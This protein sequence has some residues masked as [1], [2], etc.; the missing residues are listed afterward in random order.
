MKTLPRAV[1]G[2]WL[3]AAVA[4]PAVLAAGEPSFRF[5]AAAKTL[6]VNTGRLELTILGGAVVALKDTRTGE[7]FSAGATSSDLEAAKAGALC[8]QEPAVAKRLGI[9]AATVARRPRPSSPVAFR[10]TDARFGVL[11]YAGLDRGEAEDEW[12][13]HVRIEEQG[14][15][16][17][18]LELRLR[19]PEW[20]ASEVYL[21]FTKLTAPAVILGSGERFA[22]DEPAA[23]SRCMRI[24]N[25][26][27]APPLAVIEGA[28]GVVG[29]WP[30]GSVSA[31]DD[32]TLFHRPEHDEVVPQV[33]LAFHAKD[34]DTADEP[35]VTRSSWWRIAALPSWLD[36][37]KRYRAHLERTAGAR[38]LWEQT[39]AWVRGIHAVCTERPN[40]KDPALADA[41]YARLAERFD[42]QKLLLF[43][44]NG[45]C[46]LLFGDHRYMTELYYPKPQE[47]AA[48]RRHGFR[49]LG[50]HPYV[51]V[52]SP[53]GRQKHLEETRQRGFGVPADF[54][55]RPDY[56]GPPDAAAFDDYFRPVAAGYYAPLET[57]PSLWT[58]HPGAKIVRE[59]LAHNLGNYC[60]Q[61][62]M[63]GC[64]FDIL[65]ADHVG[66]CLDNA[67]TDRRVM[68]GHDWRRGEEAACREMKAANPD[69]ALMSEVQGAWT[70]LHTFY[71]WEGETHLTHPQPVRLNHPLRT[72]CWGSYTWTQTDNPEALPLLA[73]LPTVRLADD[74]SVARA[75]LYMDEEL[76]HD[77]PEHWDREALA[78]FRAKGGRWFQYRQ[79]P[80]GDA[81]VDEARRVR[82]GRLV[83]QA[84][85][86]LTQPARIPHWVG[87]QERVPV[88]LSPLQT[89]NFIAE[90][91]A[92]AETTQRRI[93]LRK[94]SAG[95]FLSAVYHAAGQSVVELG[96]TGTPGDGTIEVQ[97]HQECLAVF[98]AKRDTVGP[99][100]AGTVHS[101]SP[102]VPGGLVFVWQPPK[103][104]DAKLTR[105]FVGASGH[106][107][108]NG[109]PYEWWTYNSAVRVTP[110]AA[111]PEAA[112]T[113]ALELGT[114]L[115]RVWCSQWVELAAGAKP[116]LRFELA[117]PP[118]EQPQRPPP[119][120]LTWSVRVNGT[121]VWREAVPAAAG[122][123]DRAVSLADYAGRRVLLTMSAEE[124]SPADVTPNHELTPARFVNLR[125][126]DNP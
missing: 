49:W 14:E 4:G 44:W 45:N 15:F 115:H 47:I 18:R 85:F 91:P 57:S 125:I 65:G 28:R 36:V 11:T 72:A 43:H 126:T 105:N 52:F 3:L 22:R 8:S 83:R 110:F 103:A 58:L 48:L 53:Q 59:Y 33:C 100:P 10:Q 9:K 25:N 78:C 12:Q 19:D 81:Y 97:F 119:R 30:E 64:Y 17:F 98:D 93:T 42:P 113:P 101:F 71:T 5:D 74:W 79:F 35:G 112:A 106:L 86:P 82:L 38:P 1:V 116:A 73:G 55:F 90:P 111:R 104:A 2:A 120:T 46:I 95:A 37:A 13:L 122:V 56:A 51:L 96:T 27:Y 117:Y 114:G 24:A 60:R 54:T 7:I 62:E 23:T 50:Y 107:H 109:L 26:I 70:T 29:L 63:H 20:L 41:F 87:Y 102:R 77:V 32:L 80:W 66:Q 84:T 68:E 92:D 88:G 118:A 31:Y 61:H 16:S 69:L 6:A 89:Y 121:E 40:T 21:P 123:R 67:P 99:F 34:P 108:T 94:L 76:F 75:K 124:P 39:P